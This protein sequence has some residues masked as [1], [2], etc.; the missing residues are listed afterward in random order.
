MKKNG[1]TGDDN[2]TLL[3]KGVELR[4]EIRVEGTVRIDGTLEGNIETKGQVIVGED[5]LVQGTI[6][7]GTIISSGR[8][9]ATVTAVERIQLL[10]TAVLIGEIHTPIL[11]MEEGAKLQGTTDMAVAPWPEELA[12]LPGTVRSLSTRRSKHAILEQE[13]RG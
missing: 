10:K 2:I 6:L 9:K 8:I 13:S 1:F 3:A 4:G 5:G 7:A 12:K 11:M